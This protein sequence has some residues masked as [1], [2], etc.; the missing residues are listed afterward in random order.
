MC[1]CVFMNVLCLFDWDKPADTFNPFVQPVNWTRFIYV[2]ISFCCIL[3]LCKRHRNLS[4]L[5]ILF[6][7][8]D[9]GKWMCLMDTHVGNC[10]GRL[11]V[12]SKD[13]FKNIWLFFL[14]A[15]KRCI[16]RK[17]FSHGRFDR[18]RDHWSL[19]YKDY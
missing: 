2:C 19:F 14:C 1:V 5:H 15:K 3:C 12:D 8:G 16:L 6:V 11:V 18:R 13:L 4:L 17:N 9:K 10:A 7:D